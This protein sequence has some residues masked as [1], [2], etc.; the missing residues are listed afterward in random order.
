[1]PC[2]FLLNVLDSFHNRMLTSSVTLLCVFGL[3]LSEVWSVVMA[4]KEVKEFW[5]CIFRNAPLRNSNSSISFKVLI[6]VCSSEVCGCSR[7][8]PRGRTKAEVEGV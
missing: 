8:N 7:Y 4:F 5:I 2:R 6:K 3:S 1:V